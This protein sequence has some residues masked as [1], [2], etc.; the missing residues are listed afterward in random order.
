MAELATLDIPGPTVTE[1][2]RPFWE[3]AAEGKLTLQR[4]GA[5]GSAVFYP[6][7]L[8]PHCWA[9]AL[10]WETASGGGRLKSYSTIWKPGHPGWIPVTPY[11]VGLVEMDEGPTMLS[12]ILSDAEGDPIAVGDR[13]WFAPARIGGR[14]LPCFRKQQTEGRST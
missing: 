7:A 8:C 1:L 6:R 2:T 14:V 11:H 12:H 4:C 5:C 3:N 13:V 10:A 9:D